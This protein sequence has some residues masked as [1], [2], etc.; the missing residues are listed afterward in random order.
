MLSLGLS[1][2]HLLSKLIPIL[3]YSDKNFSLGFNQKIK[4]VLKVSNQISLF[5]YSMIIVFL[6]Y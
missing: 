3:I 4:K 2:N 6:E 1:Y 5:K